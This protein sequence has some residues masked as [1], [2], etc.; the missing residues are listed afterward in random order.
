MNKP[1][2]KHNNFKVPPR[3]NSEGYNK[4]NGLDP[5]KQRNIPTNL[6]EKKE[7]EKRNELNINAP[8]FTP[9]SQ[10]ITKFQYEQKN[11]NYGYQNQ[12]YNN[13]NNM[14]NYNY[15]NMYNT[16]QPPYMNMNY[17][18][19]NPMFN[20]FT[21]YQ[22]MPPQMVNQQNYFH[23]NMFNNQFPN[24]MHPHQP[25]YKKASGQK[26]PIN[27]TYNPKK[28]QYFNNNNNNTS[29]TKNSFAAPQANATATSS[30]KI[31]LKLNASN[32]AYIPK[33]RRNIIEP[34]KTN[35][36]NMNMNN[37]EEKFELDINSPGYMPTNLNLK[38]MEEQ[39]QKQ[40]E[41]NEKLKKEDNNITKN[42][43]SK[44]NEKDKN[45][46]QTPPKKEA[47]KEQPR[48]KPKQEEKKAEPNKPPSKLKDLL[49]SKVKI[50]PKKQNKEKTKKVENNIE[51]NNINK[52]RK[53]KDLIN[54][55]IDLINEKEKKNKEAEKRQKE[56]EEKR[57]KEEERKRRKEE[58]EK[59]RKEEEEK[60][61][62]EGRKEEEEKRRKE[63]EEK[64]RKEEEEKRRKEEE[65]KRKKEEQEEK[66][67]KEEE[68]KKK[69]EEE[70]KKQIELEEKRKKEEAERKIKEEQK[71]KE[72]EL[73]K[74][75]ERKRKE[76][77]EKNKVIEKK[78]FIVFKNKKSEKKE[79]KYT[80]EYIMQFKKWKI[81]NE[82]ELLTDKTKEHFKGFNEVEKDGGKP[83]KRDNQKVPYYKN[84]SN[85]P[86]YAKIQVTKEEPNPVTPVPE[87][88]MEQWA[89]KDMTKEIKAAE[90]FKQKL[91]ET[92]KDDPIKRNL[93]NYLNMLTKD[94]YEKTKKEIFNVIKDSVDYQCKFLDVL[95][96]KAVFERAF[97]EIYAK[98]CKELDKDLPQKSQP[99]EQKE[100]EKKQKPTSEMRK[101]LLDKCRE[102][103]QIE[104]NEK[105]DEYIK[106]KDPDEREAKLK[107]FVLGNVYFITELIK[108]K[109]LSKKIAP[110][111]IKN[112]FKRYENAE[113]DQ[114]LKL[115]NI[116]AIVIFTDKFGT[117]VHSQEKKIA[118]ED[119]IKFKQ[120][121]DEIFQKLEK[122][123]DEKDFPG[124]IKYRI[125]NL[126]EKRKNNYQKSKL[127]EYR[128]AK[129][130]KEVE[131]ELESQDIITQDNI[132]DKIKKGLSDYKEFVEEEG[133]SEKYP[134]KETTYLYDKKEKSL[135]DILEGY[136]VSC[137]DFIE[138]ESNIK[139]AKDYIKEL[140]EYYGDKIN[141]KEKKE[142]KNR[143]LKLLD[144]VRD[145]AIDIPKIYDIYSYIIYIFLDNNIM[146]IGELEEIIKEE[147]AIDDDYKIIS[148]IFK[149]TYEYYKKEDFKEEVAKFNFVKNHSQ[150]F[151]W[152]YKE[153][154]EE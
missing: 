71:R 67:R 112:L 133:T 4:V 73:K 127:E 110:V 114:K 122:V 2:P 120:S 40:K 48:E 3:L 105:F 126:I 77:E 50:E 76:E 95:F 14:N 19:S 66:R 154:E 43:K 149:M 124:Y 132:N 85:G 139:Y 61:R 146:E 98:L 108:I 129:S 21:N 45:E 27:Q 1:N 75:E 29:T 60:R 37:T 41:T 51:Y 49:F 145:C 92:I 134:W 54:K 93:R 113:G 87:N 44:E 68:E 9:K 148:D 151:E 52:T 36:G 138:K 12:T 74:E 118:S 30:Q 137:G 42:E 94:N 143:L 117:L 140:I 13:P 23:K 11:Q 88:S 100:G 22:N 111:C 107:N 144:F 84:K 116:E 150:L 141:K 153:D 101:K 31:P 79:Y 39:I 35:N 46:T 90:E 57:Q 69:R 20:S 34:S 72:E 8:S 25:V 15:M 56:M 152:L 103:F 89:R 91:E 97:V 102:I 83:K 26:W 6:L 135:D 55:K 70:R 121:I 81:A 28:A 33:S 142:L 59:R 123:K 5:E 17:Q 147:D 136:I 109:I 128:N 63:E 82:E 96:Q 99:K 86:N 80:F 131:Q 58:E 32:P 62:K 24:P 47:P 106:V 130:K 7:E 16:S 104:H 125:I 18:A 115:I 78:Y 64:R 38:K 53:E 119:A 10:N 65:E